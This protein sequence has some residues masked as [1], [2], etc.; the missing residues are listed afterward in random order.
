[1]RNVKCKCYFCVYTKDHQMFSP[2]WSYIMFFFYILLLNL[3]KTGQ[4]PYQLV[5]RLHCTLCSNT[6][7]QESHV[8][9]CGPRCSDY[10]KVLLFTEDSQGQVLNFYC[11]LFFISYF[12]YFISNGMP[13]PC[14][15]SKTTYHISTPCL[16]T[17]PPHTFLT[18]H[19]PTMGHRAFIG[20]MAS[21]LTDV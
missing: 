9:C 14:D 2:K 15:S 1:M 3:E 5:F 6:L 10:F 12:L 20:A 11:C 16:P 8:E 18:C 4:Y 7:T 19:S 17:I 13:F 21:P